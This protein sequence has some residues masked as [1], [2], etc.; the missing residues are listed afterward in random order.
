VLAAVLVPTALAPS[1]MGP[2]NCVHEETEECDEYERADPGGLV[3]GNGTAAGS[4]R[5]VVPMT[6]AVLLGDGL[7]GGGRGELDRS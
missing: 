5:A 2:E 6:E 1:L 3:G 7:K 4:T